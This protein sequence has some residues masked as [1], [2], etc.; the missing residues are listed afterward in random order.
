MSFLC[1]S[2]ACFSSASSFLR[3]V[4]V[5]ATDSWSPV[6]T[7][8]VASCS[9]AAAKGESVQRTTRAWSRKKEL[10]NYK[11][12]FSWHS[13]SSWVMGSWFWARSI[14]FMTCSCGTPS[15]NMG[16]SL[17]SWQKILGK[18]RIHK[19]I[20]IQVNSNALKVETLQIEVLHSA[21]EHSAWPAA[22]R[23]RPEPTAVQEVLDDDRSSLEPA[24]TSPWF[25]WLEPSGDKG[26][27][28]YF[29]D[30]R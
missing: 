20:H 29:Q 2:R 9:I 1:Y 21:W 8:I 19:C 17:G 14:L 23:E 30:D 12:A 3:V 5:S 4:V 25:H 6:L 11:L 18:A 10:M 15:D 16:L 7:P 28:D 13:E 24:C 26:E 22:G 27:E